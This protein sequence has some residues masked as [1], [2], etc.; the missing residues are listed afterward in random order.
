MQPLKNIL[1]SVRAGEALEEL[2]DFPTNSIDITVTSPPY[3][4]WLNRYGWLVRTN[5]Y[6]NFEDRMPEKDYQEWQVEILNELHRITKPGGS[7]FYNHKI[8]WSK[9]KLIHPYS[10]ITQ[11]QWDIRQEIIW[12]RT[13]AANVRGWRFWQID[14][15]IYWLYKPIGNHLV[16]EEL[17]SRHA[18]MGSIWRF[19]PVPRNDNHPASF[20]LEIPLR[21][22]YSMPGNQKKVVL[23]PFC[24]AGT[25]LVAARLLG[26]N[27]IGIDISPDYVDLA[28][29]RLE[30]YETEIEQAKEEIAIHVV[31]DP[32]KARKERGTVSWPFA[33][34]DVTSQNEDGGAPVKEKDNFEVDEGNISPEENA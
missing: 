2:K 24:G 16:G 14:E 32:F 27:Y 22:I 21:I 9:G 11:S 8:R 33:P 31:K 29:E 18:K 26:H 23:D 5:R 4:K 34:D 13:L 17:E 1:D 15:R 12:D 10:W 20:P 6:S 3:N 19:K 7:L 25:T 28:R 30:N